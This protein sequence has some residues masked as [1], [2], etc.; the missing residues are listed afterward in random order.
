MTKKTPK[1]HTDTIRRRYNR[2]ALFYDWMDK[3]IPVK[4]R[5]KAVEQATGKVLEV[6]VGTGANLEFYLPGC[7]V[8]GIDFSPGMLKKAKQKLTKARI[9][10]TLLEMDAQHM[11]FPDNT[12]DTVIA[13]CVFCSVPDPVQG[14]KE[15]KR[16][17]KPGGRIILLE[18]VRSENP[19]LGWL[20]DVLNPVALHVIGSN[21]N[22]ETVKNVNEAGIQP[23]S[24]EEYS[25]KIIKLIVASPV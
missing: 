24:I 18:H 5:R 16:V 25:G 17:C 14:L 21:I 22:R 6:G 3:M 9:P 19:F 2:T 20:M 8:T 23:Y 4:L 12:F 1:S 13:T 7:Q 15:V 11:T 10:V